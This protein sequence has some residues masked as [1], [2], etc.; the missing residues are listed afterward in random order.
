MARPVSGAIYVQLG[1]PPP[2]AFVTSGSLTA[3][4][5]K[6]GVDHVTVARR[7]ASL[8]ASLQLKIA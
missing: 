7:I 6:L 5:K 3:V 2:F 4:A 1:R 8:E